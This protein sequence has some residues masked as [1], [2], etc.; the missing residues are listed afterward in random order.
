MWAGEVLGGVTLWGA[1]AY[2]PPACLRGT[3][4]SQ[5]P[6]V[7]TRWRSS[8]LNSGEMQPITTLETL[9]LCDDGSLKQAH[10][11][12][13]S[14]HPPPSLL[15]AAGELGGVGCEGSGGWRSAGGRERHGAEDAEDAGR[16]G[17]DGTRSGW[18]PVREGAGFAPQGW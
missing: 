18:W 12:L 2:I 4:A 11:V 16:G 1:P 8:P 17:A 10:P 5:R 13:P 15:P 3:H 14:L 7:G 9:E 6:A